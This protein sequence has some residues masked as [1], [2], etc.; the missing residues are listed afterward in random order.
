M[1]MYYI[2]GMNPK[3]VE[4]RWRKHKKWTWIQWSD[5]FERTGDYLDWAVAMTLMEGTTWD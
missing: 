3:D 1:K 2:E 5:E 4:R